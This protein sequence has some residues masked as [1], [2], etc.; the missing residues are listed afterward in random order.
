LNDA[1]LKEYPFTYEDIGPHYGEVARRIGLVGAD[2]DLARFY[3]LHDH[4]MEPLQLDRHS[5]LLTEKYDRRREQLNRKCGCYLGRSRVTTLSRDDGGRKGCSYCGRCL[6]GC[7]SESLYT[8]SITLREC[9]TYP[10]FHYV[11]Q[12]FVSH[13]DYD[14]QG[15]ITAIVAS[16]V[17]THQTREFTADHY[18]LAAG[19]I[20]SSKIFMDSIYRETGE[21]PRLTGLMDNRQILIPFLNLAMLG[22]NYNP[23]T[24]QYHQIAIGIEADKPEE[25]LHGQITTL[26]SAS[27]HPIIQNVPLDLRTSTFIFKNVRAGLGVVNL[28]LFDRRRDSNYVTLQSNGNGNG[29]TKLRINYQPAGHEARLI[30]QA[31]KKVKRF[32]RGLGCIVPPSMVHVRP[33]GASVHYT[34]TIPMS[35]RATSLTVSK[36]CRSHDFENLFLVDGTTIPFLPAKNIT[37]TLMANAVRVAEVAF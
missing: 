36:Y 25:Y 4:L 29:W 20:S 37:F 24:Y 12:M 28:N 2:D 19:A 23:D 33:M 1:E 30:S 26:K 32:L 34:G 8:P 27:V 15:K 21:A 22:E 5:Q 31:V 35:E 13:F 17:A 16:H 11:P 10:N 9:L 14:T 3:P 18:V 7:P 6:W